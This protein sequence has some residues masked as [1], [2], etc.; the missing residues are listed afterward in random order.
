MPSISGWLADWKE[1]QLRTLLVASL[2]LA[3]GWAPAAVAQDYSL[4]QDQV[5][6]VYDWRIP[7]SLLVAEHYAGSAKVPGGVGGKPGVRPGVRVVNLDNLLAPVAMTPDITY[8]QFKD[9]HRTPLR[10]WLVANDPR[11]LV[12]CIVLTKG[13]PHRVRDTDNSTIGDD[14]LGFSG[15]FAGGDA[16]CAT[17]DAEL[18]LLHLNLDQGEN[19][20]RGDSFAD[21]LIINPYHNQS[22]PIGA[23]P[24]RQRRNNRSFDWVLVASQGT[25]VICRSRTIPTVQVLTPGDMYM[26]CRLDGPTV[27]D[28][29]AMIDRAAAGLPVDTDS[30]VL[31]LDESRSDGVAN[32]AANSEL[33]NDD[34]GDGGAESYLRLGDDLERTRDRKSVV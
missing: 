33:D 12:R 22:L 16:T 32:A 21:G 28:V 17:V 10:A 4:R 26:V 7:D 8:Q 2:M 29:Q 19:G 20:S 9:S 30:A 27:A 18:A 15:E 25:G 11:G 13:L 31:V 1:P 6:V 23:W 14:P 24:T 3:A 5:L 34:L